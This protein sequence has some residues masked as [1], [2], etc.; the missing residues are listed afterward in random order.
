LQQADIAQKFWA[1]FENSAAAAGVSSS[2]AKVHGAGCKGLDTEANFDE[3]ANGVCKGLLAT[4]MLLN[5]AA[6][7]FQHGLDDVARRRGDLIG[8]RSRIRE[9]QARV[10]PS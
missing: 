6:H 10:L 4:V 8:G 1:Q 2:S 5:S 7:Q 3:A 9:A